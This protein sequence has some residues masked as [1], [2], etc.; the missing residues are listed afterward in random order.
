MDRSS[1]GRCGAGSRRDRYTARRA[2]RR[3][4]A[5]GSA[6]RSQ[7]HQVRRRSGGGHRVELAVD[8]LD[9]ARFQPFHSPHRELAGEHPPQPLMWRRVEEEDCRCGRWP[10]PPR[11]RRRAGNDE[12]RWPGVGEPFVV[13]QHS[14]DVVVAGDEV[15]RHAECVGGGDHAAASRISRSSGVGSNASRRICSGGSAARVS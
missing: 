10:V 3:S 9:D 12:T 2:V 6:E 8:D 15:H 14:F 13:G 4:P 11:D 5:T 7:R 1:G